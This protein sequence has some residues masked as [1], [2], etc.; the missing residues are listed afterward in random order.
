VSKISSC[1]VAAIRTWLRERG[2]QRAAPRADQPELWWRYECQVKLTPQGGHTRVEIRDGETDADWHDLDELVDLRATWPEATTMS[3]IELATLPQFYAHKQGRSFRR[4]PGRLLYRKSKPWAH[5][6]KVLLQISVGIGA[7]VVI[8]W[9]VVHSF[10]IHA[11]SSLLAS[12]I[13]VIVQLIAYAL[14][15][16]AAIELA[17]TLFTPGPDEALDPLML[18]LSS[19]ILLLITNTDNNQSS[20]T[21]FSGVLIGVIALAALFLIRH[22]L[23]DDHDQ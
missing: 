3:P 15:I 9:N 21:Q 1:Q 10:P 4:A 6:V 19:G 18:G 22:Y 8:I 13:A 23:L 12:D 14:A 16:A 17:Y 20:I 5:G 2:F 7:V 11:N